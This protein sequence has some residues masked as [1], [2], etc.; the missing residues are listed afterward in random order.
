MCHLG[1]RIWLYLVVDGACDIR[2]TAHICSFCRATLIF[3]AQSRQA[4]MGRLVIL[5]EKGIIATDD[6]ID[7]GK[8]G[9]LDYI[10]FLVADGR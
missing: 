6:F 8:C 4:T 2:D 9:S 1:F 10:F 5:H 7:A 3:E